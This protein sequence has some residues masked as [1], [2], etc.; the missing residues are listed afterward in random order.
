MTED[1]GF[2][3]NSFAQIECRLADLIDQCQDLTEYQAAV[4]PGLRQRARHQL[5]PQLAGTHEV[6]PTVSVSQYAGVCTLQ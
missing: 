4:R 3:I 1:R 6:V 2:I 5:W